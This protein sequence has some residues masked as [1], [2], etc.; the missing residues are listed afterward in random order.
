LNRIEN[1]YKQYKENITIFGIELQLNSEMVKISLNFDVN[2]NTEVSLETQE[3]KTTQTLEN[4]VYDETREQEE[5]SNE[6]ID[7]DNE[8]NQYLDSVIYKLDQIENSEDRYLDEF[9]ESSILSILEQIQKESL[10]NALILER[11]IQQQKEIFDEEKEESE[12]RENYNS[13]ELECQKEFTYT[14]M[15]RV[16][17]CLFWVYFLLI[18]ISTYKP[19]FETVF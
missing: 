4:N 18:C 10:E 14:H 13:Y 11:L 5:E 7:D 3:T 9:H 12:Q 1:N 8:K 16:G 6:S 17:F 2:N 19:S 15:I